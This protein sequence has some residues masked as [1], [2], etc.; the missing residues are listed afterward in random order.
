MKRSFII[1]LFVFLVA[2]C[3]QAAEDSQT[4]IE[5]IRQVV[6]DQL[7]GKNNRNKARLRN[8]EI[9]E[10][11]DYDEYIVHIDFNAD[12]NFS[13]DWVKSGIEMKM[14]DIYKALYNGK[15]KV[16]MI[17]I[18][19]FF[20]LVDKYGNESEDVVYKTRL[21]KDEADKINWSQ[22]EAMLYTNIM[23]KVWQLLEVHPTFR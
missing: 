20:P 17:V 18:S 11:G 8:V 4:A 15:H 5:G 7:K 13:K 6:A 22:N 2:P 16:V 21:D 10:L 1:G 3:L 9:K 14:T 12:D 23:P 19:A